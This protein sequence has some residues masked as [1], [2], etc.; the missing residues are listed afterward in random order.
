MATARLCCAALAQ[1]RSRFNNYSGVG[2]G[3]M[4]VL[5]VD[6]NVVATEKIE[7]TLPFILQ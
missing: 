5:R 1:R 2:Q 7:H 3:G 6:G 4:G